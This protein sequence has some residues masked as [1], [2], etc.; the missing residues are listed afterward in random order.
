VALQLSGSSSQ[1]SKYSSSALVQVWIAAR[2]CGFDGSVVAGDF[3]FLDDK[4]ARSGGEKSCG[5]NFGVRGDFGD[6]NGVE[7]S[8]R[9]GEKTCERPSD[10]LKSEPSSLED[11]E[12]DS[13]LK[14]VSPLTGDVDPCRVNGAGSN[15]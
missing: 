1:L 3:R 10:S 15:A 12:G 13:V 2:F 8:K 5:G 9:D 7:V 6:D 11:E 14:V 4:V